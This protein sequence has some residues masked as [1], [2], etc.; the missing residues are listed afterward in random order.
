MNAVR[1]RRR[2]RCT[3]RGCHAPERLVPILALA[4]F[5]AASGA[6]AEDEGPAGKPAAAEPGPVLAAAAMRPVTVI[7]RADIELS[8]VKNV[9]ELLFSRRHFNRFGLRG[10][11]PLG[12][13]RA[14]FL[15]DGRPIPDPANVYTLESL[16]I[17]A[18]ERVEVLD[19][20]AA[21]LHGVQAVD[22]A[23]NIVLRRD[24]EGFE[25]QASVEAPEG[26]GGDARHGS[27]RWGGAAGESRVVVGADVFE[28]R[29]IR[30][31]DRDY[32]RA[33]WTPGGPFADAIGVSK[34]GNT[35]Y[36]PTRT[37]HERRHH[38]YFTL[39]T[40]TPM[41]GRSRLPSARAGAARTPAPSPIP[42]GLPAPA[43]DSRGRTSGGTAG[44]SNGR[45]SSS[46]SSTRS[47]TKRTSTWTRARRGSISWSSVLRRRKASPS[48]SRQ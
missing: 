31:A 10:V 9:Y 23:I 43:A 46:S 21:A 25:A 40:P 8:G 33:S 29:E 28:R 39:P 26:A 35:L 45:A 20:S 38:E 42:V 27:F 18:V 24:H 30:S 5:A 47:G 34:F 37:T 17:S 2:F 32:S 4:L 36:I 15:I 19:G 12:S 13:G 41:S 1:L 7:D 6:A 16:P 11:T 48:S 14:V 3:A 44:A 22:G